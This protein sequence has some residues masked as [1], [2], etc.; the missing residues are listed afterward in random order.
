MITPDQ[1]TAKWLTR[2]QAATTQITNG[3]NAVTVA[4]GAQAAAAS[5]LWL[6][7]VTAAQAKWVR[8]VGA[9]TLQQWQSAMINIGIPRVSTGATANQSKVLNFMQQWLP[10]EA[11]G[12]AKI[13]AMPKGDINS[14]IAR[15]TAM[16]QYNAQ[17]VYNPA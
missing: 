2:L 17:F 11:A 13:A 3:V 10:Y 4:P 6:Q 15:A 16:I 8:N 1:A 5:A 12:V 9:V 14:S 7:R